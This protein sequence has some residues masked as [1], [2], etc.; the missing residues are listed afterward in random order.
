[1]DLGVINLIDEASA[2]TRW[3]SLVSGKFLTHEPGK[4]GNASI[5]IGRRDGF[6]QSKKEIGR[7]AARAGQEDDRREHLV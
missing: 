6:E 7:R 2:L 3:Q 5:A 1:V 4:P